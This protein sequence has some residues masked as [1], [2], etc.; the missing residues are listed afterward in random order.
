MNELHLKYVDD[1]TVAES[2]N[3]KTLDPLP[4]ESR[5]QLDLY[6]SRTGQE[7][8]TEKSGTYSHLLKR[9]QKTALHI[10][11]GNK[12]TSFKPALKLLDLETLFERKKS[13]CKICQE[14][15]IF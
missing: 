3:M 10:I 5:P 12:Y 8:K 2:V 6:H 13:L 15:N 11:I 1:L 4:L 7:L 14:I 9:L